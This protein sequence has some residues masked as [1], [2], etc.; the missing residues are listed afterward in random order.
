MNLSQ[1][2]LQMFAAVATLGGVS[3]AAQALH[4]TQPALTR[5]VKEFEA[6]LGVA[7]FRR[8][9]RRLVLTHE[10]ERFVPVAQRLLSEL[11]QAVAGLREQARGLRGSV[12]VATGTAFGSTVLPTVVRAFAQSHPGVR[13]RLIDDNS[14]G[15]TERVAR[16]EAD[17]GIGSPVGDTRLLDCEPLLSAPLGLLGDAQRFDLPARLTPQVLAALPPLKE[18]ADTSILQALRQQSSPLVAQMEAGVEVSSLTLQLALARS[19]V[20]VAVLSALGA[21]H[22]LA[23]GLR[24]VPLRPALRREVF[25]RE[26]SPSPSLR[27]FMQALQQGLHQASLLPLVRRARRT[28]SITAA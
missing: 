20:G 2:Q 23:A 5:A 18:P 21:S 4:I 3:R 7:L 1:R 12:T 6:Q 25:H 22:P 16:A 27:A 9:G 17:M 19:G 10:G 26:R 14:A 24:F 15:I 11:D 8:S 28:P 13:L